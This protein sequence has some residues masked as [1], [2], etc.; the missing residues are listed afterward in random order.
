M[1][2]REAIMRF[3]PSCLIAF[4]IAT[5]AQTPWAQ[6]PRD[7]ARPPYD[8]S[9]SPDAPKRIYIDQD[10]RILPGPTQI[11]PNKKDKPFSDSTICH[12]ESIHNSQHMEERIVGNQL[13]RSRVHI[14]EQEFVLQNITGGNAEFV[15]QVQVPQDWVVDSDPQPASTKGNIAVFPVYADPSAIVRLHV[16]LRNAKALKPKTVVTKAD[17]PS[18][19][20][21]N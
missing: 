15:V 20:T 3:P 8:G 7:T 13:Y 9:A 5:S 21:G 14:A 6:Q 4:V 18:G 19:Q 16:G 17:P 10:C 2:T 11:L 1:L 12:L